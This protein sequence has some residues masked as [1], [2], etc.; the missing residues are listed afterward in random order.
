MKYLK[1][2][3]SH[4]DDKFELLATVVD[5]EKAIFKIVSLHEKHYYKD[6]L[7]TTNGD[8]IKD[9]KSFSKQI[10]NG[11]HLMA[12]DYLELVAKYEKGLYQKDEF[13][14][15]D[16]DG[17]TDESMFDLID[18]LVS[19]FTHTV[20]SLDELEF[21][22][23]EINHILTKMDDSWIYK[24]SMEQT[25]KDMEEWENTEYDPSTDPDQDNYDPLDD[26]WESEEELIKQL[27]DFIGKKFNNFDYS[28]KLSAFEYITNKRVFIDLKDD[29][30]MQEML[31][32]LKGF[33]GI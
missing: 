10:I 33:L 12:E 28:D 5:F 32:Q 3:E 14:I 29:P 15:M 19:L 4:S 6:T 9:M 25:W 27:E 16:E 8:F 22:K 21:F 1:T 17:E 24:Q 18:G 13:G 11:E 26:L 30:E 31:S 7:I 23:K 20:G 2:F